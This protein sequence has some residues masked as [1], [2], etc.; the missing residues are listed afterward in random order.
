MREK[1]GTPVCVTI[2]TDPFHHCG[3]C[4]LQVNEQTPQWRFSC[5]GIGDQPTS[6]R[7]ARIREHAMRWPTMKVAKYFATPKH[8]KN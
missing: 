1:G 2:F 7:D 4:S 8:I 6:I 5:D 3:F